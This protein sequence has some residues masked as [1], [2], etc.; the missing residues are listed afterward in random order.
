MG[1]R[2]P[3]APGVVENFACPPDY[4]IKSEMA[5]FFNTRICSLFSEGV[6]NIYIE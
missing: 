5:Y 6:L 4:L 3:C 1:N 2:I